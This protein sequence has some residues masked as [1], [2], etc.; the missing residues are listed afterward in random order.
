MAIFRLGANHYCVCPIPFQTIGGSTD[1][2]SNSALYRRCVFSLV[3]FVTVQTFCRK[4]CWH[5]LM[6]WPE[7][8]PKATTISL[9]ANDD[10]VPK[11]LVVAQLEASPLPV[12]VIVHPTA[13]H[14]GYL[15][16]QQF[17]ENLIQEVKSLVSTRP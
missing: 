17:Q 1:V 11:D 5:S 13:G 9:S 12:K 10:L 7:D 8:M 16:D 3:C 15:L 2:I 4:F 14:G 6:L